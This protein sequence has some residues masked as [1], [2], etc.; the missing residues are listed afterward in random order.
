MTAKKNAP[1]KKDAPKAEA[2][3]SA[4]ARPDGLA[5]LQAKADQNAAQGFI[6]PKEEN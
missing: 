5:E 3:A 4:P 1:A 6:G 2:P